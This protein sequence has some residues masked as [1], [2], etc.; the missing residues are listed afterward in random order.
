[1]KTNISATK[2]PLWDG[3]FLPTSSDVVGITA[4]TA[5]AAKT[6]A[7]S[8]NALVEIIFAGAVR[9][10]IGSSSP[11]SNDSESLLVPANTYVR[12]VCPAGHRLFAKRVGSDDVAGSVEFWDEDV[13]DHN[14]RIDVS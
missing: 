3:L 1:M 8:Q 2:Y 7:R 9:L 6:T 4:G 10:H 14:L 5:Y 13:V 11:N 12:R